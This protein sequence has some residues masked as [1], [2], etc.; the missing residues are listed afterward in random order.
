[1]RAASTVETMSFVADGSLPDFFSRTPRLAVGLDS[2][3]ESLNRDYTYSEY[4]RKINAAFAELSVPLPAHLDFSLAARY[5]T[6]SDFGHT[7]NP[8]IGLRWSPI[9]SLRFR[10]SWGSSFK[11]PSLVDLYDRSQDVAFLIPLADTQSEAGYSTVLV[12]TGSNESLREE[13]ASTWTVGIDFAPASVSGL[14]LSSSYYTVDYQDQTWHYNPSVSP[15]FMIVDNQWA[16]LVTRNPS[17]AQIDAICSSPVFLG[18]SADCLANSPGVVLDLRS[19]NLS[20]TT[21]SGLDFELQRSLLTRLGNF[22]FRLNGGYLF[23]FQQALTQ[24]AP[25][26][27]LVNTQGN[28]PRMRFRSVAEWDR[29]G[30]NQPGFGASVA[31]DYLDG[32]R[33]YENLP[34]TRVPAWQTFDIQLNYRTT[35]VEQWIGDAEMT[36]NVVNV[37]DKD[38]PFVNRVE[39]YD[40]VNAKP[41]GRVISFEIQKN[42]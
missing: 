4:Q 6:Y 18:S 22:N 21:V 36:L 35:L 39:G 7:Y 17:R 24:A 32:S 29:H 14:T 2:R 10:S 15:E 5:E 33:D 26:I 20:V 1:M 12:R 25:S 38:P 40:P 34:V 37:F 9:P 41:F 42:W 27:E 13:T 28:P 16:S 8:K 30:R 3:R 23:G 19:R 11:A 31:M